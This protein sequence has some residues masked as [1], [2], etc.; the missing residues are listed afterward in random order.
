M[1]ENATAEEIRSAAHAGKGCLQILLGKEA[2]LPACLQQI[3]LMARA[4]VERGG[5]NEVGGAKVFRLSTHSL[6]ADTIALWDQYT[7]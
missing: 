3:E 2:A 7:L 1:A 5:I 4:H 6:W